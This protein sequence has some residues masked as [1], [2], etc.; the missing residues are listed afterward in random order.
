MNNHDVRKLS[1]LAIIAFFLL[2]VVMASLVGIRYLSNRGVTAL[3][4]NVIVEP[5]EESTGQE[6]EY[7]GTEEDFDANAQPL[8]GLETIIE[9]GTSVTEI[10]QPEASVEPRIE[11]AATVT[12]ES[13]PS[14]E[15][16]IPD[17]PLPDR[18]YNQK[19]YT[20]VSD[21]VYLCRVKG[22]EAGRAELEPML[23]ALETEDAE[24]G[25]L[26]REI[27]E[28]V[29]R[30][31]TGIEI[32]SSVPTGLPQDDSLCIVVLG[33][34]FEH[35]GAMADEMLGRCEAALAVA[36]AYPNAYIALT[37]GGTAMGKRDVTEAAVMERWFLEKGVDP[38][39]LIIED[40]SLTTDQ[41]ASNCCNIFARQYPQIKELLVV[42]SDYHIPLGTVLFEQAA[43]KFAY[44]YG[45]ELPYKVSSNMAF[46]TA[47]DSSYS[48]TGNIMRHVWTLADPKY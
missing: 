2:F 39:R 5:E 12:L 17:F 22:I 34:Q 37:G 13:A 16:S 32:N 8:P 15:M 1:S 18:V 10:L 33:Y 45:C 43:L 40:K 38:A 44:E 30:A 46:E 31:E 41:N 35:G 24:L 20:M 19:T 7:T 29:G 6:S 26:W 47:G 21:I 4:D 14:V 23:K 25:K 48:G 27:S 28:S 42:S 3:M 36:E 11:P 9:D